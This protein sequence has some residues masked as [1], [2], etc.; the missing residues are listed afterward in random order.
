MILADKIIL[1]RKRAGW[2]QEELAEQLG[3]SRQSVSK[4][5]GAQSI[6]D[7]ERLLQMSRLF[8]VTTDYLLKDELEDMPDAVEVDA[9][10]GVRRVTMGEASD[11]LERAHKNAPRMAIAT[12]MCIVSPMVL[13]LLAGLCE[14]TEL[15]ISEGAAAGIGMGVLLALVAAAVAIFISCGARVHDYEFLEK[16]PFETEYGVHGMASERKRAF[17]RTYTSLNIFGTVICILSV[18]PLIVAGCVEASDMMCIVCVCFLLLAVGLGGTAFVWGGTIM[19]SYQRLL[20]EG[21]FTRQSKSQKS[22]K[23]AIS[24]IYWLTVTAVFLVVSPMM[25]WLDNQYIGIVWGVAGVMYA[26]L[27]SVVSLIESNKDK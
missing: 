6:P 1:L 4:W 17:E 11:Y 5:E 18:M 19:G 3:V 27:I 2:S 26:V 25:G 23:G 14:L 24:A 8:G 15:G 16:L 12:F 13:I 10:P 22:K 21:D 9:E 7:M 20:E